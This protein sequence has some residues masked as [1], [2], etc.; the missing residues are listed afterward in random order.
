MYVYIMSGYSFTLV[1]YQIWTKGATLTYYSFV[2]NSAIFSKFGSIML[3]IIELNARYRQIYWLLG[4]NF[5]LNI[6]KLLI[7]KQII[8]SIWTYGILYSSGDGVKQI[9]RCSN[10]PKQGA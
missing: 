7:Y 4:R 8:K 3:Y 5:P 10:F 9:E 1:W 6:N 2:T